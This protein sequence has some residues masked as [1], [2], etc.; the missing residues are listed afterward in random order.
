MPRLP[1]LYLLP[2]QTPQSARRLLQDTDVEF[3]LASFGA[4]LSDRRLLSGVYGDNSPGGYG[5][6]K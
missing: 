2:T 5:V 4:P 1:V 6:S 3:R